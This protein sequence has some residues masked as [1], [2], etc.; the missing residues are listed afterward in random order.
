[1]TMAPYSRTRQEL[2]DRAMR[3]WETH[4]ESY[5]TMP[6]Q[7]QFL[8]A[9]KRRLGIAPLNKIKKCVLDDY[10]KVPFFAICDAEV[11]RARLNKLSELQLICQIRWLEDVVNY[12]QAYRTLRNRIIDFT[13]EVDHYGSLDCPFGLDPDYSTCST[14]RRNKKRPLL[15]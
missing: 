5:R 1:M 11:A 15:D 6:L 2:I 12:N 13:Y 3:L 8:L 4:A 7:Y 9:E 10:P 14:H